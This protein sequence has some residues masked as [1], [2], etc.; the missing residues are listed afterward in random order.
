[1]HYKDKNIDNRNIKFFLIEV[2]NIKML[3]Y[4]YKLNLRR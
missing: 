3:Y 1:M 4:I 2:M